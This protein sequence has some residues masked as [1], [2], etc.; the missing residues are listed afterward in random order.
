V[1]CLFF[2]R[3]IAFFNLKNCVS[4]PEM[5]MSKNFSCQLFHIHW[6]YPFSF[7][8]WPGVTLIHPLTTL[9]VANPMITNND[10]TDRIL[11]SYL[12]QSVDILSHISLSDFASQQEFQTKKKTI[13]LAK[14]DSILLFL[15]ISICSLIWIRPGSSQS[16]IPCYSSAR[17]NVNFRAKNYRKSR[18]VEKEPPPPSLAPGNGPEDRRR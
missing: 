13:F 7:L 16:S 4:W 2:A 18:C 17:Q 10:I 11:Q 12:K 15:G 9:A 3:V 5:V 1:I 14:F 8:G 6:C